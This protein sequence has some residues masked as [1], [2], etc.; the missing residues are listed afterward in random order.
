MSSLLFYA[1]YAVCIICCKPLVARSHVIGMDFALNWPH[2][3][4]QTNQFVGKMSSGILFNI[5]YLYKFLS[6][7]GVQISFNWNGFSIELTPRVNQIHED[8]MEN[9]FWHSIQ[10]ALFKSVFTSPRWPDF[11]WVGPALQGRNW[12]HRV[13]QTV[14]DVTENEDLACIGHVV[15]VSVFIRPC[16][17]HLITLGLIF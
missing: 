5:C 6:A 2:T 7:S 4:I 3:V 8:V 12:R 15:F 16:G 1:T 17:P 9:V 10:H 11:I 14:E 13:M